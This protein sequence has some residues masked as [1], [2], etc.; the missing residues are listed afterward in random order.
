MSVWSFEQQRDLLSVCSPVEWCNL[1]SA[2]SY[3]QQWSLASNCSAEENVIVSVFFS[4]ILGLAASSE[5]KKWPFLISFSWP[6]SDFLSLCATRLTLWQ[7]WDSLTLKAVIYN[8]SCH[9]AP[10]R[11]YFTSKT[12]ASRLCFV[13]RNTRMSEYILSYEPFTVAYFLFFLFQDFI[14]KYVFINKRRLSW[15]TL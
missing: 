12:G 1:L 6:T 7:Q 2:W 15:L 5:R 11:L 8:I 14:L 4:S 9:E 3:D 13:F 10:R